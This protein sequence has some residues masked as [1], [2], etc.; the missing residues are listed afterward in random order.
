MDSVV[1][2]FVL[3]ALWQIPAVVATGLLGDWLLKRAP[4]RHRHALWL[5]VLAACVLLPGAS[6]LPGSPPRVASPARSVAAAPLGPATN[7]AAATEAP[8]WTRQERFLPRSF[9]RS[10]AP[11]VALAYGLFLLG[12]AARLG[13]AGWRTMRLA[14]HSRGVA[15]SEEVTAVVSRCRSVLGVGP[16]ELRESPEVAGPVILGARRPV[17]LLPTR[18]FASASS[19]EVV[20]ALGHEMVHVRRR[21]YVVNLVCEVLLLPIAFHPVLRPLRRRLAETREMACDEAVLES[22]MGSR[23]YVRSLLSLAASA[24]GVSRLSTTLGVLH[25]HSLEVR[26]KRILQD[27]P[28]IGP[29]RARSLLTAALLLLAGAGAAIS[30]FPLRATAEVP[31]EDLTPFV[32]TWIGPPGDRLIGSDGH[33]TSGWTT[34]EVQPDGSVLMTVEGHMMGTDGILRWQKEL[35]F[36][37]D[38]RLSEGTLYFR[39]RIPGYRFGAGAPNEVESEMA[40][41]QSPPDGV[42]LRVLRSSFDPD[43]ARLFPSTLLTRNGDANFVIIGEPPR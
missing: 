41:A 12:C 22:L 4:A 21:D 36:A 37:E 27:E 6:L 13:V 15:L 25:A 26:M 7:A 35:R 28:R 38:V 11:V 34:I 30:L 3:N 23:A 42:R 24:L 33:P 40:L 16:V 9:P 17:I 14:R 10:V 8:E 29:R 1:L 5:F 2:T 20:S 32:G 18:F 19:E 39:T 31:P 43:R